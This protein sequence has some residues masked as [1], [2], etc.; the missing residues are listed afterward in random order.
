MLGNAYCEELKPISDEDKE[1]NDEYEGD[2]EI[3]KYD[4]TKLFSRVR[5]AITRNLGRVF[6]T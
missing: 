2:G 1:Y 3:L 5:K 4:M 6:E